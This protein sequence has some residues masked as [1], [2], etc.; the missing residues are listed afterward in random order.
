MGVKGQINLYRTHSEFFSTLP[1]IHRQLPIQLFLQ[2]F[3]GRQ[4]QGANQV[5]LG[6]QPRSIC[7]DGKKSNIRNMDQKGLLHAHEAHS[8]W[9]VT[10]LCLKIQ[11]FKLIVLYPLSITTT[12][13]SSVFPLSHSPWT[14]RDLSL[15]VKQEETHVYMIFI[16]C[17]LSSKP[18]PN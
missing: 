18:P 16:L 2:V 6:F 8:N 13:L 15:M 3:H 9:W 1:S 12:I 11:R 5:E 4:D 10:E 17:P 7:H 14:W